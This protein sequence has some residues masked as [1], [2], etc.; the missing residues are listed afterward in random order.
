[1]RNAASEAPQKEEERNKSAGNE[2]I[3]SASKRNDG[4]TVE[5]IREICIKFI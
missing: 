1:M 4:R 5:N 3:W 2:R